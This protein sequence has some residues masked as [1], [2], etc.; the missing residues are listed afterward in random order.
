M[1]GLASLS[2]RTTRCLSHGASNFC[3]VLSRTLDRVAEIAERDGIEMPR[4]LVIQ[5]DDTI[6]QAKN[7]LVGQFL[8]T[9]VCAGKF[10]TC[11][12]NFLEV[13]HTHEDVD[14]AFGILLAKVLQRHR[15]QCPDELATM[16]EIEMANWAASRGEECHCTVL[17]RIH[18]FYEW[19]GPQGIH[20]HNCW[21]TRQGIQ[22]PHSFAYKRRHG[23]TD[24]ESLAASHDA[25]AQGEDV[26]CIVKHRMHSLH[27]NG[28]PTLVLPRDRFLAVPTLA[29]VLW[30]APMP[31]PE[32]RMNSLLQLADE[33]E[34]AT[35]DWGPSFSYFRAAAALRALVRG[36]ASPPIVPGWLGQP[37][38][39]CDPVERYTGNVYFGHLPDMSWCMLVSFRG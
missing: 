21:M 1:V 26:F 39:S 7:S 28:A 34:R 20:I 6:A 16:I 10:E 24:A 3:E 23:L 31:F 32:A 36:H 9:L 17:Q 38:V 12:F 19:L 2:S 4:H 33:L 29:P 18:D 25:N 30:E 13:G 5:S 37:A 22:A 8:A 27:P 11:T 35:E 15:V 14:L